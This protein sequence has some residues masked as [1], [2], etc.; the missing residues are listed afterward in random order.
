MELLTI[1]ITQL[2]IGEVFKSIF[3]TLAIIFA[4]YEIGKKLRELWIKAYNK[5]H[6]SDD[7]HSTVTKH[8]TEIK[9]VKIKLDNV[10]TMIDTLFEINKIQTRHTIVNT[11]T[12][13]IEK[14]YIDQLELQSLEEMYTMYTEVL[15][16]N[17]YV[18]T[19][20]YR[21]RKLEIRIGD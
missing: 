13:A 8:D 18:S 17:S 12:R 4:V 16:G 9:E 2:T 5:K 1:D 11:C 10:A 14:G 3:V 19:L 6:Q 15:K 7:F 20:M 21:V